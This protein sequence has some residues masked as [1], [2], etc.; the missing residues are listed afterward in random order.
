MNNLNPAL[1][2]Q[3]LHVGNFVLFVYRYAVFLRLPEY[4]TL[5]TAVWAATVCGFH[6]DRLIIMGCGMPSSPLYGPDVCH[7]DWLRWEGRVC[8]CVCV[9]VCLS[10]CG[11]T[12]ACLALYVQYSMSVCLLFCKPSFAVCA[13]VSVSLYMCV[14]SAS[15]CVWRQLH[16]GRQRDCWWAG[17]ELLTEMQSWASWLEDKTQ[18]DTN[19]HLHTNTHF[20][21]Y[22]SRRIRDI[23]SSACSRVH[24]HVIILR[25]IM[26]SDSHRHTE[27]AVLCI[28]SLYMFGLGMILLSD[29]QGSDPAG[30]NSYSLEMLFMFYRWCWPLTS[31]TC[32][33][34]QGFRLMPRASEAW[35]PVRIFA[36]YAVG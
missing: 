17:K 15:M 29:F 36:N 10:V 30:L 1:K 20:G 24:M 14:C 2:Q 5:A 12:L 32:T 28:N 18:C 23:T 9:C 26:Q 4:H 3:R 34:P 6:G 33:Q 35:M 21:T 8:V 16:R 11:N 13:G 27:Y 31:V 25:R 7:R 19:T 22:R